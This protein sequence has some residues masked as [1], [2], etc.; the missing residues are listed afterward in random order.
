MRVEPLNECYLVSRNGNEFKTRKLVTFHNTND[1][2]EEK[3]DMVDE[4]DGSQ[5]VIDLL[6]AFL[7]V[8][9]RTSQKVFII[10]ELDRSL[11]T[12]LTGQLLEAYLAEYGA[13]SRTQVLFTTHDL[14]LMDQ[15]LFRRDEMWLVER[16]RRSVSNLIPFS[17]FNTD[18]RYDKDIRKS[19]LQ[20]RMGGIPNI[21]PM[22]SFQ[23]VNEEQAGAAHEFQT[24]KRLRKA[25]LCKILSNSN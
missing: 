18:I 4:S 7:T 22:L 23:S 15:S 3:F 20:G 19:Y 8:S 17:D 14:L 10:D 16:D 11:H 12:I 5:R 24:N 25:M 13:D 2:S 21:Q 6:P 9:D 1:G